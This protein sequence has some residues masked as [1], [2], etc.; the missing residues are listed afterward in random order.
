[1]HEL[2][3]TLL[4]VVDTLQVLDWTLIFRI[5]PENPHS[6]IERLAN[7]SSASDLRRSYTV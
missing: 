1:M 2:W 5:Q 3:S 7:T 6:F 4:C